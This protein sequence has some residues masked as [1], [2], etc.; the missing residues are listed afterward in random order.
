MNRSISFLNETT[1]QISIQFNTL[2]TCDLCSFFSKCAT[3][4]SEPFI[5]LKSCLMSGSRFRWY[6][7]S[8]MYIIK[9]IINHCVAAIYNCL[10]SY[11]EAYYA[12]S[13]YIT[14]NKLYVRT[15]L[16]FCVT[17]LT[18]YQNINKTDTFIKTTLWE[19]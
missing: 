15:R 12:I 10:I 11:D 13:R 2:L 4:G 19:K 14:W 9:F 5:L 7:Y 18:K 1:I 17:N 8:W 16:K 3:C 6:L